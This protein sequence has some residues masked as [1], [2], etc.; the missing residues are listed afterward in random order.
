MTMGFSTAVRNAMLDAITTQAGGSAL[1]NIY[2]GT[3][4]AT[5]GA[6]SG[7][8]LLAQLTCNATFA[9]ASSGG[10]LTLNSIAN[11]T[12]AA[13]GTATWAR[14]T[15]SGG[16]FVADFGVGTSGTEIIIGTTSITS[17]ATV[18]VSSATITAGNA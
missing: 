17:G 3:R 5:G 10:V 6:L 8:T 13:T 12:A 11:A 4:P 18:S 16:T 15:T 9:P 7:N 14:L 2:S 1:L